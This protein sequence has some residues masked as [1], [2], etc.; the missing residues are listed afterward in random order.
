MANANMT[1]SVPE[2]MKTHF[3][4]APNALLPWAEVM[5]LALYEPGQGYYRKGVRPIGR[6]GD[7]YTSVSVGPLYGELLAHL[8]CKVWS[9]MGEPHEFTLV[10][11]AAHD[12][13]LAADLL[14][15]VE[16]LNVPELFRESL[17]FVIVEP[18]EGLRSAQQERLRPWSAKFHW[19]ECWSEVQGQGLAYANE[20]LD[21]FPV[22]RLQYRQDEWRELWVKLTDAGSLEW[23]DGPLSSPAVEAEIALWKQLNLEFAEGQYVDLNAG[24]RQWITEVD[25]SPF[26]GLLF[27]ADYGLPRQEL[28]IPE[29]M[30]GT[31]RRYAGHQ[32]DGRVLEQ[33]GDCDLTSHVDFTRFAEAGL[34]HGWHLVEFIE[35]GRFLTRLAASL[36]QAAGFTPTPNWIRQ[37]QTL[38]HPQHLGHSFHVIAL[39]KHPSASSLCQ[40]LGSDPD[41]ALRRLGPMLP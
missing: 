15:A 24:L 25:A 1:E 27:L 31:L 4:R 37:F 22:H 28:L 19:V 20:L 33:L 6:N 40:A 41:A 2:W 30:E 9:A 13:H 8:A 21:A 23:Q 32:C 29:R 14:A 16:R 12:G 5:R 11:Q 10:E 35:Q 39:A 3:L 38:T 17:R 7:F 34:Q 36:M 18:D 26:H